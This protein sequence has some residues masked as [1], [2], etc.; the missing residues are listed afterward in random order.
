MIRQATLWLW[1]N[2]I[3][4]GTLSKHSNNY[5]LIPTWLTTASLPVTN[6]SPALIFPYPKLLWFSIAK[7]FLFSG[8]IQSR[9]GPLFLQS[10]LE[11][12]T[13]SWNYIT[14]ASQPLLSKTL[15]FSSDVHSLTAASS[16]DLALFFLVPFG[17]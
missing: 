5:L 16:I 9:S 17:C 6:L 1:G 2:K 11:S 12:P 7:L 15:Y 3:E 4:T 13:K 14:V 10:S 8:S